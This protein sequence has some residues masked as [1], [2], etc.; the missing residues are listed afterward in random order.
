M[1]NATVT[2]PAIPPSELPEAVDAQV[3][4]A[5]TL[6]HADA[7]AAGT[8]LALVDAAV[9]AAVGR[10]AAARVHAFIGLLVERE[11][12]EEL[13]LQRWTPVAGSENHG[14][15]AHSTNL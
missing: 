9:A 6:L 4:E 3:A 14:S 5:R 8:D 7:A 13:H 10:Y 15:V 1:L 12:R 2:R 11:V